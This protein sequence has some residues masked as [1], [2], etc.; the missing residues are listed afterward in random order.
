MIAP[1]Y[2]TRFAWMLTV[3]IAL[4]ASAATGLGA[5][6]VKATGQSQAKVGGKAV[7]THQ[8]SLSTPTT[9]I[10]RYIVGGSQAPSS[11]WPFLDDVTVYTSSGAFQCTGDRIAANWVLTAQHCLVD[12]GTNALVAPG[13]VQ[14]GLGVG[15]DQTRTDWQVPTQI[16]AFPGYNPTTHFGDIALLELSSSAPDTQVVNLAQAS[17]EPSS[18]P[19]VAYIAGWGLTSDGGSSVNFPQSAYTYLWSQG[20]CTAQW[21][22]GF[23]PTYELCA[24][25]PDGGVNVYP[26]IC[27]GDS[28]GPLMIAPV[29]TDPFYDELL[30]TSDFVS[31]SGCQVLPPVFERVSYYY[32]WL[33]SQTG[34]GPV[35][36]QSVGVSSTGFNSA[37]L[38]AWLPPNEA[39]GI[40]EVLDPQGRVVAQQQVWASSRAGP[41]YFTLTGLAPG[42]HYAGYSVRTLSHYGDIT[43]GNIGFSTVAKADLSVSIRCPV[44]VERV[45]H[46]YACRL[47]VRNAGPNTATNLH[48]ILTARPARSTVACT[49]PTLR[50]GWYA[51]CS[52]SIRPF[53]I[54]RFYYT[55]TA[56][57]A[58][59]DPNHRNNAAAVAIRVRR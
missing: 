17:D 36:I 32:S 23:N 31:A 33:V 47:T 1:T 25:G 51:S 3:A 8:R 5:P 21:V 7:V 26:S 30:G 44:R 43:V 14:V 38:V 39:D 19:A 41:G 29:T 12:S 11:A 10:S 37:T 27:E 57:S 9:G 4:I 53:R 13:S 24:G 49:G 52:V 58:T 16:V 20:F 34:L 50:P 42:R 28:G 22:V 48:L 35:P 46:R 56:T 18:L 40:V 54:G 45:R 59:F 55:V 6:A 15:P 2:R